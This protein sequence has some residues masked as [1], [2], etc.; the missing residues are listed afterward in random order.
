MKLKY[1]GD[2]EKRP[3]HSLVGIRKD[4][5]DKGP[6]ALDLYEIDSKNK[7]FGVLKNKYEWFIIMNANIIHEDCSSDAPFISTPILAKFIGEIP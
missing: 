6:F 4:C 7:G 3:V 5:T 2:S 1:S